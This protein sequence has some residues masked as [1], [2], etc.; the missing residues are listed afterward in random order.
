MKIGPVETE[1]IRVDGQTGGPKEKWTEMTELIVT[2][3]NFA[4]TPEK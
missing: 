3:L 1:L 2:F 4:N